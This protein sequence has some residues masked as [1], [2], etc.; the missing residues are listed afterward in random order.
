VDRPGHRPPGEALDLA[1]GR[2]P[3]LLLHNNPFIVGG[4]PDRMVFYGNTPEGSQ[5]FTLDL[6]TLESTQLTG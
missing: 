4:E 1:R 3:Q 5:L 6:E 2:Q